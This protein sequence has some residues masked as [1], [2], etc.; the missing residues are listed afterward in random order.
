[1]TPRP[2]RSCRAL[3][4]T[5]V[6]PRATGS[7]LAMRADL[8]RR[9]LA[10][11][12]EVTVVVVDDTSGAAT[13]DAAVVR[14]E[15]R[16]Q[17][18]T[19]ITGWLSDRSAR[20]RLERLGPLGR[21]TLVASPPAVA[22]LATRVR[23]ERSANFDVVYA[24]RLRTALWAEPFLDGARFTILDLDDD[25]AITFSAL[26]DEAGRRGHPELAAHLRNDAVSAARLADEMAPRFQ[27]IAV[28]NPND[29]EPVRRHGNAEVVEVPNA[30][31]MPDRAEITDRASR[32]RPRRPRL[33]LVGDFAYLPNRWA[34]ADLLDSIVPAVRAQGIDVAVDLVGAHPPDRLGLEQDRHVTVHGQVDIN[35]LRALLADADIAVA[36]IAVGGGTRLKVL[37]AWAH[38][39]PVVATATAV[40]GLRGLDKE[41]LLL[42]ADAA[43]LAAAVMACIRCPEDAFIRARNARA[44]VERH[45]IGRVSGDLATSWQAE[46][47]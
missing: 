35:R 1:M 5:P 23:E 29:V 28:A 42:G 44:L 2:L 37:E 24:L 25:E 7:G 13:T 47:N 32:S 45:A 11:V 36:P 17:G 16:S 8:V 39:L 27:R 20:D 41:H 9:A 33:L 40:A 18:Q 3:L 31:A 38:E 30:V 43:A 26:A 6:L 15:P 19:A 21:D 34:A 14:H 46:L 12:A 22:V 10:Q 4:V